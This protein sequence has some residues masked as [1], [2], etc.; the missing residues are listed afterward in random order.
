MSLLLVIVLAAAVLTIAYLAYGRLLARLLRLNDDTP[1]PAVQFRDDLDYVP[2]GRNPLLS[3]HFSAIAA[4]GPIVGPILAGAMFGWLPALLWILVG[5]IFI[6]GV[7]DL[8]ALLASVR[9]KA[10]SIAEVVRE[11]MS[12]RSYLLFL[13]FIWL[14]LVYVVVA[15]T[16]ITASSFIGDVTLESGEVVLG[17]GIAT[18]SLM[19]L[20]LPVLMGL[21]L[22]FARLPLWAATMIFLPLVGLAIWGG[23]KLPFDVALLTGLSPGQ[24]QSVWN[25]ALLGYCFVASVIPMW[26][27][28]QPRGHLGGYFLYF[29]LAGGALGLILGGKTVEYPAF[30]GWSGP[31]A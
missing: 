21:L 14:A 27:L 10:R 11:Y 28:L 12:R 29:A 26:L 24:A 25:V 8:T 16:D 20:A 1:T 3:Q 18:S 30:R 22:R 7:H 9:H 13:A 4:A 6:G 17:G 5:A 31:V 2:I 23:Q 19:Y 15:F